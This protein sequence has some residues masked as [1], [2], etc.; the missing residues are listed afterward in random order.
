VRVKMRVRVT[1]GEGVRISPSRSPHPHP[2]F[3]ETF[4]VCRAFNSEHFVKKDFLLS[5]RFVGDRLK[6]L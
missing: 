3:D 6:I 5:V 1:V 2:D 4:S